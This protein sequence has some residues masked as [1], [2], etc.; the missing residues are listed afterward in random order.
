[1]RAQEEICVPRLNF[2]LRRAL[3]TGK[4]LQCFAHASDDATSCG[5][6]VIV[7]SSRDHMPQTVIGGIRE[8]RAWRVSQVR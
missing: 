6:R 2:L 3:S 8:M 4:F 5:Q 1:V 7:P